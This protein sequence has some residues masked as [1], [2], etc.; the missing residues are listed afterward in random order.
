MLTC[1]WHIKTRE[2]PAGTDCSAHLFEARIFACPY[3]SADAAGRWCPDY[4]SP[5]AVRQ[6]DASEA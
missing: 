6:L 5:R 1:A 3:R 4:E 2:N